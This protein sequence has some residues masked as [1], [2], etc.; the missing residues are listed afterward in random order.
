MWC[1]GV[2][3]NSPASFL[4]VRSNSASGSTVTRFP[5]LARTGPPHDSQRFRKTE[6]DVASS[7]SAPPVTLTWS[8]LKRRHA[9]KGAPESL[10]HREQWQID[11][12]SGW[13]VVSTFTDPQKQLAWCCCVLRSCALL[14]IAACVLPGAF[15]KLVPGEMSLLPEAFF[16]KK[17]ILMSGRRTLGG[18]AGLDRHAP[19]PRRTCEE[20]TAGA[21]ARVLGAAEIARAL[22]AIRPHRRILTMWTMCSLTTPPMR[23][24][25]TR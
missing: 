22:P 16:E 9:T 5:M 14:L 25:E 11:T 13:P 3:S 12:V 1:W 10:R 4:L 7:D 23:T 17:K 24:R 20:E 6:G 2:H 18:R 15:P 8:G 19:T 21:K